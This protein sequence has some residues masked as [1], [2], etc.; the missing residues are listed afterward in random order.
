M[1]WNYLFSPAKVNLQLRVLGKGSDG[2]HQLSSWMQVVHLG[3][4]IR[5][6]LGPEDCLSC[7]DATLPQDNTNLFIQA[8]QLFRKKS[9]FPLFVEAIIDKR[10]PVEAGLGGGSSNA[11]TAL[12]GCNQLAK[13]QGWSSVPEELLLDWAA[14]IG[15]D[16]PFFFSLG[17]ARCEGR[18]ERVY[19]IP[20]S[21]KKTIWIVK[22]PFGLSTRQVFHFLHLQNIQDLSRESVWFNDLELPAFWLQPELADF[23]R[24]AEILGAKVV[25]T[26]SGSAFVGEGPVPSLPKGWTGWTT[27]FIERQPGAWYEEEGA[28]STAMSF[29]G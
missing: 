6:R 2:Y 19:S 20:F 10:I 14:E 15:A 24:A 16:V 22:P 29:M 3:D 13:E 18:G 27:C 21:G 1:Q 11:A 26:G 28:D 23:K 9:G 4:R 8:V 25:M 5:M 12:F 7:S 17:S